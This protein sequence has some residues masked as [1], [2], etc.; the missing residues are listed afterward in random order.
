MLHFFD[1]G[2]HMKLC[3]GLALIQ[4]AAW[5]LWW[6]FVRRH[7]P[8]AW[9]APAISIA[10][11]LTLALELYDFPP[12]Y[13]VLDAH[14]LWHASTVPL[15]YLFW[16]KFVAEEYQWIRAHDHNSR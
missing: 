4:T 6:T 15:G 9:R 2:Y 16:H 7:R 12:V 5:L 1:Y 11:Q 10:L 3:I 14:A 8:H 13:G